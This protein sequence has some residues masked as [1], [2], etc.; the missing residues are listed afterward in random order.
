[1]TPPL[2]APLAHRLEALRTHLAAQGGVV[3]AFSGGVDSALLL[4]VAHDVL[5]PR[6]VALTAVSPSYAPWELAEARAL[7]AHIG[8]RMIEIT[9]HE[10]DRPGYRANQ[11][12]RCYHCKAELFD[13]A[14]LQA[15]AMDHGTLVYGAIPED[16]GDH[17]P[18]MRAANERA[19]RA[20]LIEVGLS[21]ADVRALARALGLPVWDKPAGAC[22]A[23]RFPD[24]TEV[25]ADRLAQVATCEGALRALGLRQVRAR[26]HGEVVRV[27]IDAAELPRVFADEALRA[28]VLAAGQA[29]G[30]RH[31]AVDLAGYRTGSANALVQVV[32]GRR[33]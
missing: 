31:V 26:Y 24:G 19:V 12:D 8:A 7:A 23:S 32:E 6:A 28:G 27:E 20:P 22:L 15:A 14:A 18:G 25:T 3:V 9:T 10:L 30:F 4:K 29:G 33:G 11:G 21:K 13:E 17:R 5:G 1:V 16:L 2:E